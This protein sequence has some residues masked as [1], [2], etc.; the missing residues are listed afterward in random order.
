MSHDAVLT[1][2]KAFL[3]AISHRPFDPQSCVLPRAVFMVEPAD[4]RVDPESLVDNRYLDLVSGSDPERAQRQSRNLAAALRDCGVDLTLFP[5]D[6]AAPDGVFSNNVFGTSPGRAV[7]GRMRHPGRRREANRADIRNFL[8]AQ[9]YVIDDLSEQDMVAELTGSVVIDRARGIGF[10]GMTQRVDEAGLRA[11]HK[12][13]DLSLTFRFDLA[14]GEYHTNVVLAILAGRACV[15]CPD[16]VADES[17]VDAIVAA[18]PGRTLMLSRAEKDAFAGNC[19]ALTARDLFMSESGADALAAGARAQLES[20]GFHLQAVA[21][22]E[23]EKAGGSLR[24]MIT[25]LF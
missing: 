23:I 7:V 22:D 6:P 10:C 12:A 1:S 16:A 4:F 8:L 5:G 2:P 25:E 11:M 17:V 14:E 9:G 19:I 21:L 15:I 3:E 24:C 18:F 20:W 13:F